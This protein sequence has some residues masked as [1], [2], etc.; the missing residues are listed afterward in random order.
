VVSFI[1][2]V[3][4]VR[5]LMA[6]NSL[7]TDNMVYYMDMIENAFLLDIVAKGLVDQNCNFCEG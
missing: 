2:S 7:I 5:P 3:S 1:D 4:P 6:F